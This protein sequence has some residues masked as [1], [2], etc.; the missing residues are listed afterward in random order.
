MGDAQKMG[1]NRT[2]IQMSPLHSRDML[3]PVD[4]A[5]ELMPAET[6]SLCWAG[7]TSKTPLPWARSRCRDR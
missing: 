7:S 6:R 3:E 4:L 5:E 2:G 1:M